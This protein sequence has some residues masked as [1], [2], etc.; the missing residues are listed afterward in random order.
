MLDILV[1]EA[2]AFAADGQA[3]VVTARLV[4]GARVRCP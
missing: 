3:D 1:A 4:T 2:A